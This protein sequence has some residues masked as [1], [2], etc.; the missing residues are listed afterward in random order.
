MSGRGKIYLN[1]VDY[2]GSIVEGN[3]T[4]PS[5]VTPTSLSNLKIDDDYYSISGGGGGGSTITTFEKTIT[6]TQYGWW[7]VEDE[8]GNT[9]DPTQH[10]LLSITPVVEYNTHG[11]VYYG[12]CFFQYVDNP[13]DPTILNGYLMDIQDL[14]NGGFLRQP[15]TIKVRVSYI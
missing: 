12:C 14:N 13:F 4:V 6:T 8:N 9:L 7:W 5:G 11:D 15:L 2:S 10:T 3:P 1:G